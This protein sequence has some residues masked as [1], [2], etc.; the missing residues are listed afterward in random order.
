MKIYLSYG[1]LR[2]VLF[3]PYCLIFNFFAALII[4]S[5]LKKAKIFISTKNVYSF[6]KALKKEVGNNRKLTVVRVKA[7]SGFELSVML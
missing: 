7:V 1:R 3:L 5:A 6:L 4:S 2:F